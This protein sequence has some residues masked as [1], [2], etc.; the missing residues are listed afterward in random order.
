MRCEL[1]LSAHTVS[2]YHTDI[3]QFA[4]FITGGKADSFQ[5][6]LTEPS[7]LRAWTVQLSSQGISSR[8]IKRK[9]SALSA[10][11]RF[12]MRQGIIHTNP[13]NEVPLAKT[14]KTLPT[15]IRQD[16]I[17]EIIAEQQN[18]QLTEA[19]FLQTRNSL[20]LLL[21]YTT[22]IRLSEL[23]SLTDV[24]IDT[25][26]GEL[27]VLGKRNKERLIPFGGEL[28]EAIENYL[29]I[30]AR[31]VVTP[32]NGLF[33]C[34]PDGQPLYATLVQRI[35]HKTL[36]G[37]TH[38]TRLSPHTLRHSFAT[39][40]LNNGADLRS[41]QQLLGHESLQTTQIYT[42]LTRSDLQNNYKLAHPRAQKHGG[43]D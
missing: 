19:E 31:C 18:S 29:Q 1:N 35:I 4:D 9:M 30:R 24:N 39:D 32:Q 2:S 41:V 13:A 17:R 26:R 28:A 42:H 5:P 38:A 34:R 3:C 20:I 7:D 8:S 27:K 14:R 6:E 10:L 12:L 25:R 11:F 37:H 21:F 43:K 40:M 33:F 23:I 36:A 15:F 22:G 16:E